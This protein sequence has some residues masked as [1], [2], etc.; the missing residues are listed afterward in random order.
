MA[1]IRL[2][3]SAFLDGSRQPAGRVIP[4]YRGPLADWM[5]LRR[6]PA[7]KSKSSSGSADSKPS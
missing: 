2:T 3:R 5:E 1:E 4:D 7:A 6:K